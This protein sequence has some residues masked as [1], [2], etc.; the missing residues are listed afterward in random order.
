LY[1]KYLCTPADIAPWIVVRYEEDNESPVQYRLSGISQR[2]MTRFSDLS[3]HGVGGNCGVFIVP[4][5]R[6]A[7][8][9][10]YSRLNEP[11]KD[12]R[13]MLTVV[14]PVS[15]DDFSAQCLYPQGFPIHAYCWTLIERI[16][17]PCAETHLE[18]FT[19]ALQKTWGER[20]VL[21]HFVEQAVWSLQ[22]MYSPTVVEVPIAVQDPIDVP[23]IKDLLHRDALV[24]RTNK[25][26]S[27]NCRPTKS[28]NPMCD[29]PLEITY[30]ILD[31]L[32]SPDASRLISTMN[33]HIPDAY[34]RSRFPRDIIF[35]IERLSPT[36]DLNWRLLCLEAELLLETS[37]R[38]LN[39]Q[40]IFQ[41]LI[42]TKQHFEDERRDLE[43]ERG[44]ARGTCG[45][46]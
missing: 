13:E 43:L 12:S 24:Q 44:L 4:W 8:D 35:E 30:M 19:R 9:T 22:Y 37:K 16:I 6:D 17:G 31:Y 34:W 46:I 26:R 18:L 41:I 5:D 1:D 33:W 14:Y 25:L 27:W 36:A 15:F 11:E 45:F 32:H 38:L 29:L 28:G 40:R 39:R 21:P 42:R 10:D 2:L 23:D 7:V 20:I 3:S